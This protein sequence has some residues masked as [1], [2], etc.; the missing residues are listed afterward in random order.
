MWET[1]WLYYILGIV[2]LPGI[3][4][5]AWAQCKVNFNY[6]KYSGVHSKKGM[7]GSEV[8]RLIL[9]SAGLY[10]YNVVMCKG[11]LTDNFNPITK[12]VSLS[13]DV[14]NSTSVAS[15]G[16]ASHEVGHALQYANNYAPMK[17]RSV[18]IKVS[19][20]ASSLLWPVII[21]GLL[22]DFVIFT[23]SIIGDVFLIC[24]VLFFGLAVIIDLI[25]L[26]VEFNASDRAKKIL[27]T[28]GICDETEMVG[29]KKVLN[30]A[31][32]TYIA[33]LLISILNLVRFLLLFAM[34]NK[35]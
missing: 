16:I 20:F 18:A 13:E 32:L 11:T 26:P 6:K 17:V 15:L 14:Y 34:K 25:T 19:N 3:I 5:G 7:K 24:G 35:D 12:T 23:N 8:A 27:A 28:S 33:S 2:L 10:D 4:L 9:D 22:F 1:Y 31:A 29:V 30:S 21:M